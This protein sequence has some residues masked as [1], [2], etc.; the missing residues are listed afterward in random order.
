ML[1][2]GAHR[3]PHL[4]LNH[5]SYFVT[6]AIVGRRPLLADAAIKQHLIDTAHTTFAESDW[7][8]EHWVVLD[9]HYHLMARSGQGVDLP[10][11]M[12]RLHGRTARSI[13]AETGCALPVWRNYW[14]YCPRD[15]DDYLVHVNYLFNNPIK[16]GCV[17][18]L[19]DYP[20]SSFLTTL[21]RQGREVLA[22][23]FRANPG[24]SHPDLA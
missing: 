17:Q 19:H 18:D 5:A 20:F 10:T 9:D 2:R 8:L 4:L 11:V 3:P 15:D 7:V 24:L 14:D 12:R 21:A 1:T 6:G 23:Q 22:T 16:H 13:R